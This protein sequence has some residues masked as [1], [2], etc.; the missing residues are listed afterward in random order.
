MSATRSLF[1]LHPLAVNFD[2]RPRQTVGERFGRPRR[3]DSIKL[4]LCEIFCPADVSH[5]EAGSR[6][7]SLEEVSPAEV[8]PSFL[9]GLFTGITHHSGIGLN[10]QNRR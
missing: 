2:E 8:I 3:S 1:L 5:A 6:G 4:I 9:G 10:S 7:I